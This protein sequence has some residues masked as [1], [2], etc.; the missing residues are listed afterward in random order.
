MASDVARNGL[1]SAS[2]SMASAVK[3]TSA[4]AK[5]ITPQAKDARLQSILATQEDIN[6]RRER[7]QAM[8]SA[9]TP[10]LPAV[11]NQTTAVSQEDR[12]AESILATQDEVNARRERITAM[13]SANTPVIPAVSNQTTAAAAVSQEDW[14]NAAAALS[15]SGNNVL[16]MDDDLELLLAARHQKEQRLRAIMALDDERF[17]QALASRGYGLQ[18]LEVPGMSMMFPHPLMNQMALQQHYSGL[19]LMGPI[20]PGSLRLPIGASGVQVAAATSDSDP[21]EA[22]ESLN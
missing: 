22:K 5:D 17:A 13:L 4:A 11:S 15:S 7:I 14:K 9:N 16:A 10:V 1:L 21:E 3:D 6:T 20:L 18:L 8:L 12:R 19:Y 2:S